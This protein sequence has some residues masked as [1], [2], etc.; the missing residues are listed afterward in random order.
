MRTL[1]AVRAECK[2][3]DWNATAQLFSAQAKTGLDEARAAIS[4]LLGA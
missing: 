1:A 4:A 3:A 2:R